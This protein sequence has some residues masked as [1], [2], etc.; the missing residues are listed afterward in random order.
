MAFAMTV[1]SLGV[2]LCPLAV[3]T[4]AFCAHMQRFVGRDGHFDVDMM[5]PADNV[6]MV[7]L[8]AVLVACLLIVCPEI[9]NAMM[10]R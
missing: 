9:F 3:A 7:L 1:F 10:G 2:A 6:L 8:M 4:F 5:G